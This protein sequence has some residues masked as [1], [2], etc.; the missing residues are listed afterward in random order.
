MNER[1]CSSG[2]MTSPYVLAHSL[3][4]FMDKFKKFLE[5]EYPCVSL[6]KEAY[7]FIERD[8]SLIDS[9]VKCPQ[10]W[11]WTFLNGDRKTIFKILDHYLQY[12]RM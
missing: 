7:E 4:N 1:V 8:V 12:R 2:V 5:D 10:Y 9:G 11:C 3:G 6:S